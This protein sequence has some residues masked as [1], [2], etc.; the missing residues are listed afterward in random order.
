MDC[1][2]LGATPHSSISSGSSSRRESTLSTD[3]GYHLSLPPSRRDSQLSSGSSR[4]DSEDSREFY[5]TS[6]DEGRSSLGGG[7]IHPR[8]RDSAMSNDSGHGPYL[9]VES[10]RRSSAAPAPPTTTTTGATLAPPPTTGAAG[11]VSSGCASLEGSTDSLVE[12]DLRNLSLSVT[13]QLWNE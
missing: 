1:N 13:E 8:R 2:A 7:S 6:M 12:Q 5:L 4:R 11:S 3:S 9:S 10:A